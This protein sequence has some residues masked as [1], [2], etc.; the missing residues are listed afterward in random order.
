MF[1]QL[2]SRRLLKALEFE[3]V[4]VVWLGLGARYVSGRHWPVP[5]CTG[6]WT[7][8]LHVMYWAHDLERLD[9]SD[10]RSGK[11]CSLESTFGAPVLSTLV[12]VMGSGGCAA[13]SAVCAGRR[14]GDHQPAAFTAIGYQTTGCSQSPTGA[15]SCCLISSKGAFPTA[16]R[17]AVSRAPSVH[18]CPQDHRLGVLGSVGPKISIV[19]QQADSHRGARTA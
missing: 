19:K 6:H 5:R 7:R 2:A 8:T 9:G 3:S 13:V 12:L 17:S 15:A 10:D 1:S 16:A 4:A 14:A 11:P 18:P